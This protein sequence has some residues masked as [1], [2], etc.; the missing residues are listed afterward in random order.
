RREEPDASVGRCLLRPG[1]Q[2]H[3]EETASQGPKERAPVHP[4]PSYWPGSSRRGGQRVDLTPAGG[5]PGLLLRRLPASLALPLVR[6]LHLQPLERAPA[7]EFD[8][9]GKKC[10]GWVLQGD[11]YLGPLIGRLARV[12]GVSGTSQEGFTSA[13]FQWVGRG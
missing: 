2:R 4:Q 5:A 3:H 1:G 11:A 10:V 7:D 6:P 12:S 9:D 13:P 8:V